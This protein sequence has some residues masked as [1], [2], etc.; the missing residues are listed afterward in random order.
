MPFQS[1]RSRLEHR[2]EVVVTVSFVAQPAFIGPPHPRVGPS[3]AAGILPKSNDE[4]KKRGDA[5]PQ[6]NRFFFLFLCAAHLQALR[7][8]GEQ[9]VGFR[10]SDEFDIDASAGDVFICG[11]VGDVCRQYPTREITL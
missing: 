8:F 11:R 10:A 2:R 3:G 5:F 1:S 9:L 4:R 6:S 7:H